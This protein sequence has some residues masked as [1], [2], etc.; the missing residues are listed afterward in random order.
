M[1]PRPAVPARLKPLLK[2]TPL[3]PLFVRLRDRREVAAWEASGRQGPPPHAVKRR[4][5]QAY[6]GRHGLRTFVES[7]TFLGDMVEGLRRSMD[8]VV[9]IELDDALYRRAQDRFAACSNVE[10]LHGDSGELLRGVVQA[11]EEPAL[12]WLDGH[13]SG[14]YTARGSSDTPIMRELT[15]IVAD[16]PRGHVVLV[17][18]A[19]HFDG[20]G[21]YP[22][23]AELREFLTDR[24]PGH[25]FEVRDDV[26][27]IVLHPA[28]RG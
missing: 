7:G 2:R 24:A 3:Y 27:R 12:F 28:G 21:D 1:S 16:A 5:L 11:I 10:V 9:T 4:A 19:R 20:Q 8:R 25:D 6:A 18:D 23:I 14:G 15:A 26:I 22:S 13:Y 17:D